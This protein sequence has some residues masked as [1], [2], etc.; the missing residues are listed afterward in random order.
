W[1]HA[2]AISLF[3]FNPPIPNCCWAAQTMK[4]GFQKA[5]VP[6]M[7]SGRPGSDHMALD[8]L[9]EAASQGN[10]LA[11][12]EYLR[13][14]GD[15]NRRIRSGG[16]SLLHRAVVGSGGVAFVETLIS[17]GADVNMLG[18]SGRT[19]LHEACLAGD[20]AIVSCLCKKE[21]DPNSRC[22]QERTPLF[23][24]SNPE[25]AAVLME[26][27]ADETL[28]DVDGKSA[29]QILSAEIAS[30]IMYKKAQRMRNPNGG[31][32][33]RRGS[34]TQVVEATKLKSSARAQVIRQ[35][36]GSLLASEAMT[37][38]LT[39][40]LDLLRG[41]RNDLNRRNS[42]LSEELEMLRQRK[43]EEPK[44]KNKNGQ[45]V[46][47]MRAGDAWIQGHRESLASKCSMESMSLA[48]ARVNDAAVES[49][50]VESSR[51]RDLVKRNAQLVRENAQLSETVRSTRGHLEQSGLADSTISAIVG[52][53]PADVSVEVAALVDENTR[54]ADDLSHVQGLNENVLQ[55]LKDTCV[56]SD[57]LAQRLRQKVE[58][59]AYALELARREAKRMSAL[60]ASL[61]EEKQSLSA[62]LQQMTGPSSRATH[63]QRRKM[64]QQNLFMGALEKLEDYKKRM[65]HLSEENDRLR[66]ESRKR[67]KRHS[68]PEIVLTPPSSS[69]DLESLTAGD[70]ST[71]FEPERSTSD[72][73]RGSMSIHK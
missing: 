8:A 55:N 59:D 18:Q 56:E 41:Q 6:G 47:S 20:A 52:A 64:K 40:Q 32:G 70:A 37:K 28:L 63:G 44:A 26:F 19:P 27:G 49:L 65:D 43:N 25:T 16:A 53:S 38:G 36:Q 46:R 39:S 22:V 68:L 10:Q 9:G 34:V 5:Q 61:T 3:Y 42:E 1:H 57:R 21:A 11:I 50:Q 48:L 66:H 71:F 72:R 51:N 14:G 12:Q 4:V 29:H 2:S 35:L 69:E 67:V 24:A 54:L 62:Q 23:Y 13:N 30:M 58:E 45:G 33:G 7:S 15:I 17:Y 73:T 60:V 31:I